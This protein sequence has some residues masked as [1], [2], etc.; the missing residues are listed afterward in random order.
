VIIFINGLSIS[1]SYSHVENHHYHHYTVYSVGEPE[2]DRCKSLTIN[3]P[4]VY[5][6][7]VGMIL[8]RA[9][10]FRGLL[11]GMGPEKR[12]YNTYVSGDTIHCK[13]KTVIDFPVPAGM[14]LIK[15]SLVGKN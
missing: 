15:L 10:P 1:A 7:R 9:N 2:Q 4:V 14:S 3:V 8:M 6:A 13:K 11:E 5:N 12:L